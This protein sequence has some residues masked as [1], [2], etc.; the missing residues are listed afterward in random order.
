MASKSVAGKH[1]SL[2]AYPDSRACRSYANARPFPELQLSLS[3]TEIEKMSKNP[4]GSYFSLNT[5]INLS[6]LLVVVLILSHEMLNL[7][8][9]LR[10]SFYEDAVKTIFVVANFWY[11]V[12]SCVYELWCSIV[13]SWS[14]RSRETVTGTGR[15]RKKRQEFPPNSRRVYGRGPLN[16]FPPLRCVAL[17]G[18]VVTVVV[19]EKA[20]V[21]H[22]ATLLFM[23]RA[24]SS[25]K[26]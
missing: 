18:V 26:W 23:C 7:L 16:I 5:T 19:K 6:F 21:E 20:E 2:A 4:L 1:N 13:N 25:C 17:I 24:T 12:V 9:R 3:W 22:S 8:F 14:S 11:S 15:K 10:N